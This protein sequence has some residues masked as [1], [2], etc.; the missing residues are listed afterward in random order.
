MTALQEVSKSEQEW[1]N[2]SETRTPETA[3]ICRGSS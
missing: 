1:G 3:N 2:W